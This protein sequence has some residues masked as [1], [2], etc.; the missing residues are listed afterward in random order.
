MSRAGDHKG[1]TQEPEARTEKLLIRISPS[2]KQLLS[3]LSEARKKK[4]YRYYT[5]TDVL[6]F[7][8]KEYSKNHSNTV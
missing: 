5:M 8:L 2:E 3:A 4:G 7:A 6:L 1:T